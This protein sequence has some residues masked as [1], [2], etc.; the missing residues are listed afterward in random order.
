MILL[1]V[2]LGAA[3][4]LLCLPLLSECIS[5][6][7]RLAGVVPA[8]VADIVADPH[9]T[10]LV[11]AHDEE[12]L[13]AACVESLLQQDGPAEKRRVIVVADN[14]SDATADVGRRAGATVWERTDTT[15]RGKPYA[16]AWALERIDLTATDGIVI[17][18]ADTKVERGFAVAMRATGVRRNAV[19][20]AYIGVQ[21]PDESAITRM[22]SVHTTAAHG[23]A[24]RAKDVAGLNVPLGVGM[25]IGA[26]ILIDEPW[27]A[28]SIAEDYELYAILTAR[29]VRIRP[30]PGARITAQEARSLKQSAP[31]RH[32]WMAGKLDVLSRY[33]GR[34]WR[35]RAIGWRQRFDAFAELT[36]FG[37]AT[38]LGLAVSTAALA[39]LLS[40]PG[41]RVIAVVALVSLLR[42]VGYTALAILKDPA[43]LTA[44]RAFAFLP[45]YTVWRLGPALGSM[46]RVRGNAWVR[47]G[48]HAAEPTEPS[49][50]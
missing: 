40:P 8:P 17:I 44:L 27:S 33:S 14:C 24:Y 43:P 6:F 37:P 15:R 21:N 5:K 30:A 2:V 12:L 13:L 48:R 49:D 32:R 26:Q 34:L 11:L 31:Q 41:W 22:A 10:F 47:T 20:Q 46:L 9:L 29:G 4:L 23:L 35:S 28:F 3:G 36:V 19:L 18:D 1:S 38:H 7:R 50:R 42:P 45:I 39:W 25:C 16:I